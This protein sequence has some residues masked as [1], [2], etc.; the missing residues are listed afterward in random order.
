MFSSKRVALR[1]LLLVSAICVGSAAWAAEWSPLL[2]EQLNWIESPAYPGVTFAVLAG[3]MGKPGFFTVR[4]KLPP[5][6]SLV[7]T[8]TRMT[9]ASRFSW[10]VGS[11]GSERSSTRPRRWRCRLEAL[12]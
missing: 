2:P 5:T 6:T 12:C 10:A 7:R 3:G 8:P 1:G 11:R 9:G 4:A